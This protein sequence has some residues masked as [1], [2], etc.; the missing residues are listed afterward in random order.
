[1]LEELLEHGKH[2][3]DVPKRLEIAILVFVCLF[4]VL[5]FLEL[6]H[7]A[8]RGKEEEISFKNDAEKKEEENR[9][10]Y[11]Q[12]TRNTN[13]LFQIGLNASFFILRMIMWIKYNRDAAIFLA[14]NLISIVISAMPYL[15]VWGCVVDKNDDDDDDVVAG[16]NGAGVGSSNDVNEQ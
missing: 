12:W 14:K 9:Q 13:S 7:L 16:D 5:S 4:Y 10:K 8:F 6:L 2:R 11:W 15:I 1:M 3:D